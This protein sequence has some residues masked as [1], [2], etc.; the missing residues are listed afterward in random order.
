MLV[1]HSSTNTN[2]AGSICLTSSRQALLFCS[3]RS[4]A[5]RLFFERPTKPAY[6]PAHGGD[7]DLISLLNLPQLAVFLQSGVVVLL[8]LLPQGSSVLDALADRE[9]AFGRRFG[10]HR[11]RLP[12]QSEIAPYGGLG[13][14]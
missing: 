12:S 10:C 14:S 9:R 1:P 2:L 3:F 6:S 7:R 11:S 8:E 4:E 13:D 5:P